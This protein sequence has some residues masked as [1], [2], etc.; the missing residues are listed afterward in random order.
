[1]PM[2]HR[3]PMYLKGLIFEIHNLTVDIWK[4]W[5]R[6]RIIKMDNFKFNFLLELIFN[7]W[8][9]VN[10]RNKNRFSQSRSC[11]AYDIQIGSYNSCMPDEVQLRFTNPVIIDQFKIN[12]R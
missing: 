6:S 5:F 7:F 2:G 3:C 9:G 10:I 8:R 4:K 11:M 1:M 12:A